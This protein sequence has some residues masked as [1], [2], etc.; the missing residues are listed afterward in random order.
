MLIEVFGTIAWH[1]WYNK[2]RF[3]YLTM[4]HHVVGATSEEIVMLG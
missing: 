3:V 2:E 1:D 4:W